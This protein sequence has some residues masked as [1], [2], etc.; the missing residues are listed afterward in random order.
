MTYSRAA[1]RR[2]RKGRP[3]L[4]ATDRE[5]NGRLSRRRSALVQR[6]RE[7]AAEITAVAL[8]ARVKHGVRPADAARAEAG[9]ALGRVHLLAKQQLTHAH[10]QAGLRFGAD[11][12]RYYALNGIARPTVR[13]QDLSHVA[14]FAG[15][16]PAREA[17]ARRAAQRMAELSHRIRRNDRPGRPLAAV[18]NQVCVMDD[19]KNMYLPHMRRLLV[20]G[21]DV[22]IDFYGISRWS[23]LEEE[24]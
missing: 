13:A 3:L 18:L 2:I 22:L 15:D 12:E 24:C 5:P 16:D 20:A 4:P 21:L 8:A 11:C 7:T 10:Y 19:D 14:G 1:R 17:E 6:R 23:A 9:S